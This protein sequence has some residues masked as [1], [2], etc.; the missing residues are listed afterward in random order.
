MTSGEDTLSGRTLGVLA[1][2]RGRLH[3]LRVGELREKARFEVLPAHVLPPAVD[4]HSVLRDD[5]RRQRTLTRGQSAN[6]LE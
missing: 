6:L 3:L 1:G 5:K 4:E 2:R